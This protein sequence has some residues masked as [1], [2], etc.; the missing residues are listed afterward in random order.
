M[1]DELAA[2]AM[3]YNEPLASLHLLNIMRVGL[4]TSLDGTIFKLKAF[5]TAPDK[6]RHDKPFWNNKNSPYQVQQNI[7]YYKG[8]ETGFTV[9][10]IM[11]DLGEPYYFRGKDILVINSTF[12]EACDQKCLFCEDTAK[13]GNSRYSIQLSKQQLFG[14]VMQDYE[15]RNLEHLRQIS[16]LTSCAG[17]ESD[18]LKLF[19]GYIE[20]AIKRNFRGKFYVASHELRSR[21]SLKELSTYGDVILA[22]TVECFTNRTKVMPREKGRIT[23]E[24]I[25]SI[26]GSARESGM[27]TNYLYIF[28]ID[29]LPEMKKGFFLLKDVISIAPTGPNYQ[30]T[31]AK[32]P[33]PLQDL[34][35]YLN[36][37][38][39]FTEIHRGMPRFESVQSYRSLWPLER[40]DERTIVQ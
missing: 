14:K 26:L 15:L 31:S 11:E 39:I 8:S 33:L 30:P 5:F 37:R 21:N 18:A 36:A 24:E 23:L 20:E 9:D 34:E 19:E 29:E 35:Y 40:H 16:V 4:S 2:L 6:T 1:T 13:R 28:G 32:S 3:K 12:M 7:V 27:E 17:N 38:E 10:S 22:F 25:R